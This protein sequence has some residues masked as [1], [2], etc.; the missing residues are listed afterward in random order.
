MYLLG[1]KVVL[2]TWLVLSLCFSKCVHSLIKLSL[3]SGVSEVE[4]HV[5]EEV[6][7]YYE[8]ALSII[9]TAVSQ[10][11]SRATIPW[12]PPSVPSNRTAP[13]YIINPLSSTCL[14]AV[15]QASFYQW[16]FSSTSISRCF[17]SPPPSCQ[18]ECQCAAQDIALPVKC[19]TERGIKL[20][21][22]CTALESGHISPSHIELL[23][24][25]CGIL[26]I[27]VKAW[28]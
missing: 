11:Q 10:H 16:A 28:D 9:A 25:S 15:L 2:M 24:K 8:E 1:W 13:C 26:W 17:H 6:W 27:K 21:R 7:D 18:F 5:L 3:P 22:H 19:I 4:A 20:W 23:V 12:L 14:A